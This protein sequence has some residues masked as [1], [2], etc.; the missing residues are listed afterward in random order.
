MYFESVNTW[1]RRAKIQDFL[2]GLGKEFSQLNL[3]FHNRLEGTYGA[4]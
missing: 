3:H 1:P 4:V 2:L